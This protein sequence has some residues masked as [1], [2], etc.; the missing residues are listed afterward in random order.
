MLP[1]LP[2]VWLALLVI[3]LAML[4]T[5]AGGCSN[6]IPTANDSVKESESLR[7]AAMDELRKSTG[8]ID[9][10]VRSAVAGQTVPAGETEAATAAIIENLNRALDYLTARD[11]KLQ[12]A[13]KLDLNSNY[14]EYLRLLRENNDKLEETVSAIMDIPRLLEQEQ[15]TLA[16]SDQA[17]TREVVNQVYK[18][19]VQIGQLYRESET[20]RTQAEKIRQD[21][22]GDFGK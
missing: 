6:E 9:G 8:A 16:G 13:Q 2:V 18:M 4:V 10:L 7:A 1:A 11:T 22:P 17:K 15:D 19:Q 20:L 5:L 12:E 21:S 14:Q 3:L